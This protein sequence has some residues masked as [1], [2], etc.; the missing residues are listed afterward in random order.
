MP[1]ELFWQPMGTIYFQSNCMCFGRV[2]A[3]NKFD[4]IILGNRFMPV[5]EFHFG[6]LQLGL[7]NFLNACILLCTVDDTYISQN[8]KKIASL[9]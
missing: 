1:I 5:F 8:G 3:H 4:N 9:M 7:V 6:C 2:L